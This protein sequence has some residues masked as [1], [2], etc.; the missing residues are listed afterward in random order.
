MTSRLTPI[1]NLLTKD[2]QCAY[3]AKDPLR[4]QS[5]IL[6][7]NSLKM[8][9]KGILQLAYQKPLVELTGINYGGRYMKK[10]YLYN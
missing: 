4:M 2:N 9:Y 1:I 7:N 3:K 8:K 10:G 5:F 6:N